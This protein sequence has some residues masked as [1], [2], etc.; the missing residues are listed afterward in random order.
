MKGNFQIITII[1]FI[2]A[3]IFGVLVFSGAIPLGNSTSNEFGASGTV[4]L[5]G[6]VRNAV[7]SDALNSFN[8][9]NKDFNVVYVEKSPDTFSQDLLE[10]LASG[11]GPDMFFLPDD[12]VFSYRNKTI[13][14]P[15]DSFSLSSFKKTFAGAGDVF[16]T[17][18]GILAMPIAVDPLVMYYNR[19]MLEAKGIVYPP[20]YWD[21]FEEMIPKLTEK[22]ENQKIKK[23][24]VALGQYSNITRAKDILATLFMQTGNPIIMEQDGSLVSTL[25]TENK[26]YTPGSI[27]EFYTS[28]ADP[29]QS[30]YSWNRSFA[31]S[32]SAFSANDLVFYFD[33]ASEFL[34]LVTR[35]PNQ[36]FF[37][38]PMPQVRDE[39]FKLTSARVTGIAVSSFS[40]NL[41]TAFYAA[42][43]MAKG[44]FAAQFATALGMTPVRKDLLA[45][46]PGGDSYSPI[47]YSSALYAR[48]WLDPSPKDTDD[49]FRS[50]VEKVL[51]NALTPDEAIADAD[52][53][54]WLLL[55]K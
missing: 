27:L 4:T 49:I 51:S 30:V 38:A 32:S 14:I 54:M 33:Y 28:F 11:K 53:K 20:E 31:S 13:P 3:A 10:A 36:N 7:I 39:S 24:G 46:P 26:K 52:S 50:T 21:E 23:S 5:W 47:F 42:N 1:V 45:K 44:D 16:L 41:N 18:D 8:S 22:D 55:Q 12:L 15:Y 29:L 2:L 19:G 17:K 48:S 25:G 9:A 34:P 35:N 6:T 40:K 37:V 43:Q